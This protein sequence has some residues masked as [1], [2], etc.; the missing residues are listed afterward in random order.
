MKPH[1]FTNLEQSQNLKKWGAPQN[2]NFLWCK[3]DDEEIYRLV[4][5]GEEVGF[6]GDVYVAAYSLE[7]LIEWLPKTRKST[8]LNYEVETWLQV[9]FYKG[10]WGASYMYEVP[11]EPDGIDIWGEGK[12]SILEAIYSLAEV[13]FGGKNA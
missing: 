6:D 12:D 9:E 13:L 2:T 7:E 11:Y 8:S 1:Y 4:Y 5:A 10:E 3:Y